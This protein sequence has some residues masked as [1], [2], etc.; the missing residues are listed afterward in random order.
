MRCAT[1]FLLFVASASWADD[2]TIIWSVPGMVTSDVAIAFPIAR[3][4]VVVNERLVV[5]VFPPNCLLGSD[6]RFGKRLWIFPWDNAPFDG[7]YEYGRYSTRRAPRRWGNRSTSF[8]TNDTNSI[9]ACVDSES[10]TMFAFDL[11]HEGRVIW[12]AFGAASDD[13]SLGSL[14]SLGPPCIIGDRAFCLATSTQDFLLIDL[15]LNSGRSR[16]QTRLSAARPTHR[17]VQFSPLAAG[18]RLICPCP[19]N[20][21]VA[22]VNTGRDIEWRAVHQKPLTSMFRTNVDDRFIVTLCDGVATCFDLGS[23]SQIW[24]RQGLGLNPF[25]RS[26]NTQILGSDEQLVA[27]DIPTGNERWNAVMDSG[28]HI[29]ANGTMHNGNLLLPLT[30]ETIQSMDA[31]TGDR[32]GVIGSTRRL[33]H[34]FSMQGFVYSLTQSDLVKLEIADH[35]V[36]SKAEQ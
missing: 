27:I 1:L 12:R 3:S 25:V 9:L 19:T 15:D 36:P 34:L 4:P 17:T 35:P 2:A 14:R 7:T 31:N 11:E 8:A 22:V 10:G 26:G 21:L 13:D 6:D 32:T 29:A 16:S 18:A 5:T 33:G 28:T 23:G 30:N 24:S 20:E